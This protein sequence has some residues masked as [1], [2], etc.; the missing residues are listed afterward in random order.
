M[1]V[2][3][4]T[5]NRSTHDLSYVWRNTQAAGPLVPF[6]CEVGLPNDTWDIDLQHHVITHPTIGPLFGSFK[7]QADVF[8]CPIRL[9]NAMLH[10]NA[11]NVG[12]NMKMVKLPQIRAKVTSTDVAH[13]DEDFTQIN[14]SCLLSYLGIK[15]FGN[16]PGEPGGNGTSILAYYDI[17]KNFY[18][19]K[20]E[21]TFPV[22]GG[23]KNVLEAYIYSGTIIA[24]EITEDNVSVTILTSGTQYIAIVVL[25]V[26]GKQIGRAHV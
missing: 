20:Q 13:E 4:K 15:G 9:Y 5:Y 21:E 18:A 26:T 11:L 7:M 22:I 8:V 16:N 6:I 24:G 14:P 23:V 12:L 19:N 25:I 17:F 10:N 3:L 1:N 2:E